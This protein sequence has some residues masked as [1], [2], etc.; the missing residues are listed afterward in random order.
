M[1]FCDAEADEN[2]CENGCPACCNAGGRGCRKAEENATQALIG[3]VTHKI[4]DGVVT[5]L[6]FL[7]CNVTKIFSA[8]S[9]VE[10]SP[11]SF[12]MQRHFFKNMVSLPT[13]HR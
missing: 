12:Q 6:Q 4:E 8:R 3:N 5:E 9:G 11:G 2:N 10:R 7:T 1:R 13:C